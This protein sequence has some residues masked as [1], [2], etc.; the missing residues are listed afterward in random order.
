MQRMADA[1]TKRIT[2]TCHTPLRSSSQLGM[3]EY[4]RYRGP[5][6]REATLNTKRRNAMVTITPSDK[7]GQ[8][9]AFKT[10]VSPLAYGHS[11]WLK[12]SAGYWHS[13]PVN[14]KN[15]RQGGLQAGC[16]VSFAR[17]GWTGP[18]CLAR[19]LAGRANRRQ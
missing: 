1:A 10:T 8:D 5:A 17:G 7:R 14:T 11:R 13:R 4:G 6:R 12:H 3:E 9:V 18:M 16:I 19:T 15:Y 2:G